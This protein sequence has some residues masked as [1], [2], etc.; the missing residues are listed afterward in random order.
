M[1]KSPRWVVKSWVLGQ[2]LPGSQVTLGKSLKLLRVPVK[3]VEQHYFKFYTA[4]QVYVVIQYK[5][6]KYGAGT[7]PVLSLLQSQTLAFV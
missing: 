1:Q 3:L 2:I 6:L 4:L 5:D 7:L